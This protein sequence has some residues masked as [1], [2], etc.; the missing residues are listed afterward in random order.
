M[1]TSEGEFSVPHEVIDK[2]LLSRV[3]ETI[4]DCVKRGDYSDRDFKNLIKREFELKE[5]GVD[6]LL[7]L[8]EKILDLEREE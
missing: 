3:L 8:Y 5:E 2:G 1:K 7:E 6:S 4:E